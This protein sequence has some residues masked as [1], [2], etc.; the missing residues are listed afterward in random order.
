MQTLKDIQDQSTAQGLSKSR[1]DASDFFASYLGKE[2]RV[3]ATDGRIFVG[4]FQC[5][6]NVEMTM[7]P[8]HDIVNLQQ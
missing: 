6:D 4:Q 8:H 1:Q 2:L 5:T 3:Y 7:L